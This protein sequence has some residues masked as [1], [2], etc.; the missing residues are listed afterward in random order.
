MEPTDPPADS[1][2][3]HRAQ[4]GDADALVSLYR[5]YVNEMYGYAFNQL[6]DAQDAE[7][8]TSEIFMRVVH[9]IRSYR[10]QSSFR[11]WLYAIAHNQLRDHW[12]RNGRRAPV[13][14]L[15]QAG[16][17]A[18]D[19]GGAAGGDADREGGDGRGPQGGAPAA[20]L[21][22]SV[23]ARLPA[24]Y[25]RVLELRVMEGRSVRDTADALGITENHVKVLNH[26]ALK[27]AAEVAAQIEIDEGHGHDA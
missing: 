20:A 6:G 9:G 15:E 10:G 19:P 26:R 1:V 13:V 21:G 2:L 12:R 24:H 23:L 14:G 11:T 16:P 4:R 3:V 8:L 27:R 22:R 25:R 7:D 17:R 18:A 5:R